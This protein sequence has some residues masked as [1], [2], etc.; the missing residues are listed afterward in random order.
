MCYCLAKTCQDCNIIEALQP[1]LEIILW[2]YL[3][4]DALRIRPGSLSER[5]FDQVLRRQQNIMMGN[6]VGYVV[7]NDLNTLRLVK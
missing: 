6:K 2:R 5:G 3:M 7:S 1:G 4:P